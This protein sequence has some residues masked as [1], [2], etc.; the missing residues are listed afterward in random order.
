MGWDRLKATVVE[1]FFR[2]AGH[3]TKGWEVAHLNGR[4]NRSDSV[5]WT[6]V[7]LNDVE[8]KSAIIEY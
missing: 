3:G 6:P 4:Q 1:A 7:V 5:Y 8:A 2:D